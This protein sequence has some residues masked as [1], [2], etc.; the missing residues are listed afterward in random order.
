MAVTKLLRIKEAKGG[1]P[2]Q[3]LKN[4]LQYICNPE[5]TKDGLYIGGNSGLTWETAYATMTFNKQCFHKTDKTQAFHYIMSFPPDAEVTAD[6][7]A[8]IAVEFCEELLGGN[9]FYIYAIHD[10]KPHMHAHIIFD[11]V[12]RTDGRKFHSPRGDWE[13]RI[14]PI[15]DRLCRKHGLSV[16]SYGAERSDM[17]YEEW[18]KVKQ[19]DEANSSKYTW[20]DLI[21]DDVDTAIATS[22]SYEE[23]L[24]TLKEQNYRIRDGKYLS[25]KPFGR[26]RAVRSRSLGD[27]YG[28]EQIRLRIE[29][30][31][32][33]EKLESYF[34]INKDTQEIRSLIFMKHQSRPDWHMSHYQKMFYR[35]WRN[36]YFIRKPDMKDVWKKSVSIRD[37][38]KISEHIKYLLVH[39]IESAEGLTVRREKVEAERTAIDAQAKALRSRLYSDSVNKLVNRYLKIT[40]DLSESAPLPEEARKLREQIEVRMNF[41]EAIERRQA[42]QEERQQ[43]LAA[44]KVL[45]RELKTIGEL[46]VIYQEAARQEAEHA[47]LV[48][49]LEEKTMVEQERR[50]QPGKD[51]KQITSESKTRTR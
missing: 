2:A 11:S 38:Y 40:A 35:R 28:K 29:E 12:S 45:Q 43:C 18:R 7:A 31:I 24:Q 34:R 48:R 33:Q 50:R 6:L 32:S 17:P 46:D 22:N 5:K 10:D 4:S 8:Q 16:L 20:Y 14:Q 37:L 41:G 1:N 13:K 3:Q 21:R 30:T 25:L 19:P 26:Q 47:K 15:T 51:E 9:Y 39:D 49:E 42:M 36:T 44:L 23:F 27:G